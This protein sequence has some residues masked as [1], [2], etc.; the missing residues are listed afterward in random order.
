MKN[1]E[2]KYYTEFF[3]AFYLRYAE[4]LV[5]FANRFVDTHVAEDIV[6]DIFIK[7]WDRKSTVVVERNIANYLMSAVR[8]ACYDYLKHQ[9]VKNN[10]MDQAVHQLKMDELKYYESSTY[11]TISKDQQ[12]EQIYR[13]IDQLPDRRR[14]IFKKV[15]L[16]GRKHAE[17]AEELNISIRTVETHIYQALKFLRDKWT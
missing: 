11:E 8:R 10:F 1:Q 12:M 15:F 9:R 2:G 3:K 7:I 4:H 16:E 5:S 14:E 13:W 17:V 6:H